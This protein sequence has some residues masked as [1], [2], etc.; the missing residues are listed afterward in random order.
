M[1]RPQIRQQ[2]HSLLWIVDQLS[3]RFKLLNGVDQ[4]SPLAQDR[5]ESPKGLVVFW[6]QQPGFV[7][8]SHSNVEHASPDT[9]PSLL[10]QSATCSL[11]IAESQGSVPNDVFVDFL[12][13]FR[14]SYSR[15]AVHRQFLGGIA[16]GRSRTYPE[17][18][19]RDDEQQKT[20]TAMSLLDLRTRISHEVTCCILSR[21]NSSVETLPPHFFA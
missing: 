12:Q 10:C 1:H 14:S 21:H 8:S 11:P 3:R 13:V 19:Q 20:R 16:L 7:E 6:V 2:R 15:L 5:P 9:C 4:F 17:N 18:C